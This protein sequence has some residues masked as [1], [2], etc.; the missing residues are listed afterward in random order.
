MKSVLPFCKGDIGFVL[1]FLFRPFGLLAL[2]PQTLV[3][4][5]EFSYPV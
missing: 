4:L 5:A 1:A 3:T 2:L